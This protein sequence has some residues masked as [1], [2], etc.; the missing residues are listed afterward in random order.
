MF[1]RKKQLKWASLKV[2]IVITVTLL[3]IF[4]VI[5]FSGGI[6][7]IFTKKVSMNIFISDV[8]GL[9]KGAPVRVAGVDIGEVREIKLNKQYGTVVTVSI[10]KKILDFLKEDAKATVLTIGLLGDKYIEISPGNSQQPLDIS[11]GIYGYPQIEVREVIGTATSTINKIEGVI[12]KLDTLI[13]KIDKAEGTLPKL[14]N[15]P[16]L[17]NNLN[18]SVLQLHHTLEE[19][20]T[21]SIGMLATDKELYEQLSTTV[22]NLENISNKINSSEGSLGKLINDPA[23]YENLVRIS[24]RLD[25]LL[26]EIDKS[27]GTINLLLRDKK[28][29][30][31]IKQSIKEIKELIEEIKKNPKK[32]FKFSVF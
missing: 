14:I 7:S 28:T 22:K 17:Y 13:E 16:A 11:K 21:G 24:Q 27:E 12:S 23:L 2:G 30:E 1:D 3:I 20:R 6:E 5:I 29:A 9:R 18:K 31:D 10:D 8:K 26:E 25:K 19:L 4:F 15:D 32:F